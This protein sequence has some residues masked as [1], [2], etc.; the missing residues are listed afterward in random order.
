MMQ[1]ADKAYEDLYKEA[2]NG[3]GCKVALQ[4]IRKVI[5]DSNT[6]DED[7]LGQII[8]VIHSFEQDMG[9]KEET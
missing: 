8:T 2:M 6:K 1:I 7:K 5:R 3:I 4:A 9:Q